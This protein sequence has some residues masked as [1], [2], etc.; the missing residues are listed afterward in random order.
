M[1]IFWERAPKGVAPASGGDYTDRRR[2]APRPESVGSTG[3]AM[4]LDELRQSV[5]GA[6][7]TLQVLEETLGAQG[8]HALR[9]S[10]F[11]R[12]RPGRPHAADE[13]L[14]AFRTVIV[15]DEFEAQVVLAVAPADLRVSVR[16]DESKQQQAES[17]PTGM[18]PV[19]S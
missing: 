3:V 8:V 2:L 9:R 17:D 16:L 1:A 10:Y 14:R 6:P 13:S 12:W 11:P 19:P 18:A 15:D 7:I 4:S 5:G